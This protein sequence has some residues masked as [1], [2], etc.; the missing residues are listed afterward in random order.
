MFLYRGIA[1]NDRARGETHVLSPGHDDD[2]D[3]GLG[4]VDLGRGC[5]GD[6]DLADEEEEGG[7]E[8]EVAD[9]GFGEEDAGRD[10][11]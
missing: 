1:E 8:E 9:F 11:S 4:P 10:G 2:G 7:E 6:E 5:S 3:E